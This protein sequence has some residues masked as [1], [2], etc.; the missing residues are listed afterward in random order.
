MVLARFG[1]PK[2]LDWLRDTKCTLLILRFGDQGCRNLLTIDV[3][4][5]AIL[6]CKRIVWAL[7]ADFAI[8]RMGLSSCHGV[9]PLRYDRKQ[10]CPP[11]YSPPSVCA[12][13]AEVV[14]SKKRRRYL[15]GGHTY[16]WS[17]VWLL[18]QNC[19]SL[20]T[21]TIDVARYPA[22]PQISTAPRLS[23]CHRM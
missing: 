19:P 20:I 23:T 6:T 1:A 22:Q 17:D 21:S 9:F 4:E 13:I 3:E 10:F 2:D 5:T 8:Y 15:V 16:R 14:H 18:G 7:A 11:I 12:T